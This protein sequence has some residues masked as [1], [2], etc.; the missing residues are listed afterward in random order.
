MKKV[1]RASTRTLALTFLVLAGAGTSPIAYAAIN[2]SDDFNDN[3]KDATKWGTD[4]IYQNGVLTETSQHLQ[5]TCAS[6]TLGDED[7]AYRPWALNQATYNTNWEVVLDVQNTVTPTVVSQVATVGVEIFAA[8]NLSN[9]VYIELYSSA[10]DTLPLR[11]GFKAGVS[12]GG[13]EV[14]FNDTGHL[15]VTNGAIRMFYNSQTHVFSAYYDVGGGA[16]NGY[17]WT[18]LA[19]FGINSSGGTNGNVSWGLSGS[20]A[21]QVALYGYDSNIGVSAGQMSADN[22]SAATAAATSPSLN[23]GLAGAAAVM[24]WPQSAVNFKLQ[25]STTLATNSWTL[26]SQPVALSNGVCSVSIPA[27]NKAA[28]YRLTN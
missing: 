20:Q 26:T 1:I 4:I 21:F 18:P 19:S 9:S 6:P 28:F 13:A 7:D 5:Y 22:F 10:L 12:L 17:I 25:Q 2:G 24:S 3:S 15:G 14:G 23:I 27:T 16:T 8:N 11:R